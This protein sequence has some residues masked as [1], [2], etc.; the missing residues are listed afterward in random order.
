M[1]LGGADCGC[2]HCTE[3][4]GLPEP[5]LRV[6]GSL[7]SPEGAMKSFPQTE[8]IILLQRGEYCDAKFREI[9]LCFLNSQSSHCV[10]VGAECVRKRLVGGGEEWPQE[11]RVLGPGGRFVG[12]GPLLDMAHPCSFTKSHQVRKL[13]V[14]CDSPHN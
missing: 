6:W 3:S 10:S 12:S 7:Q 1:A 13:R 9:L 2:C 14:C 11:P 8:I 4:R 5:G